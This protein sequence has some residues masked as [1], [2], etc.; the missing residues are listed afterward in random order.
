MKK[1][2]LLFLTIF[3]VLGTVGCAQNKSEMTPTGYASD[4]IQRP[5]IM[6]NGKLYLYTANGFDGPLPEGYEYVGEVKEV[7]N[8][9]EPASDWCGSRV[10]TG[11][12]I[13]ASKDTAVIYVEYESGYAEFA[14]SEIET[15]E[16]EIGEM[17]AETSEITIESKYLSSQEE[18]EEF[19]PARMLSEDSKD[20]CGLY[21]NP[22]AG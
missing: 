16:P 20:V 18:T 2:I 6:Y 15:E 21:L 9:H 13:Y 7:D 11:Q 12:R 8:K 10:E 3:A 19:D 17:E 1:C 5:Q 22:A 14:A 4:E